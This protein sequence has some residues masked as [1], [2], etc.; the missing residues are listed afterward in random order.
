VLVVDDEPDTEALFKLAFRREI[1]Q[2]K[3]DFH[4]A[5]NGTEALQ[6]LSDQEH[7]VV[8]ILSDVNMPGMSGLDLLRRIRDLPSDLPVYMITAYGRE[9]ENEA[10]TTGANGF[11]TKPIDF[12]ALKPQIL[13]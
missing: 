1:R 13:G 12:D 10:M 5:F 11:L 7:H 6:Y 3:I 4:F 9:T 2:G 8:L